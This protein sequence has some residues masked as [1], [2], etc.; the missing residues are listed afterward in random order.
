MNETTLEYCK[1]C[2][3][4]HEWEGFEQREPCKDY[5]QPK[6]DVSAMVKEIAEELARKYVKSGRLPINNGARE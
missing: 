2:R 4:F 5:K 1:R 3:D 6:I